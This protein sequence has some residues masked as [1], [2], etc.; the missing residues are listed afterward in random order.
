[1]QIAIVS[2]SH[3]PNSQ[4]IKVARFVQDTIA[5]QLPGSG[6]Y[7]V[8]LAN[9][10]LPLWDEADKATAPQWQKSWAPI[11]KELQAADALVVVSPEWHGMVPPGLKNFL[12][13]CTHQELGD[14]PGL[15]VAVS[16]GMGGAYP[17]SELRQSG[18][19]N[20]FLCW[21]PHHIVIRKA[22]SLLN[23]GTVSLPE[24]QYVRD[25]LS[26]ALRILAKYAEGLALVRA[27]GLLDRSKFGN[28]M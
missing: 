26:N 25:R 13:L 27:S 21:I 17:V 11:A 18:T 7:L 15:I 22:E 5:K 8:D 24:D 6:T 2:G 1:M 19:K 4:S 10:P 28:G 12:L 3:R 23:P 20:N 14:K 16:S 9:N